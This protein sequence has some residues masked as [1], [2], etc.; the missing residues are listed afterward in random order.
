MVYIFFIAEN[1]LPMLREK[2]N[3][4]EQINIIIDFDEKDAD[5]ELIRFIL[6]YLNNYYP[7]LLA[8][9]HVVKFEI[10]NLKKNISFRKELETLNLFRVCFIFNVKIEY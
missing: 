3:F 2:Y 1:V 6:I 4:S 8:K 5:T 10:N 9:M 7:L